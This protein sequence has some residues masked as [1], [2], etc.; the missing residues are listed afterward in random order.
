[1]N[2]TMDFP[3]L[4]LN[5]STQ[6][7]VLT[8]NANKEV[9]A[10]DLDDTDGVVVKTGAQSIGGVKTFTDHIVVGATNT[11]VTSV[12]DGVINLT[13]SQPSINFNTN[14]QLTQTSSSRVACQ[15]ADF[16]GGS[17]SVRCQLFSST[18]TGY[19]GVRNASLSFTNNNYMILQDTAGNTQTSCSAGHSNTITVAGTAYVRAYASEV[20]LYKNIRMHGTTSTPADI[21]SSHATFSGVSL[22]ADVLNLKK[23]TNPT[24]VNI[25]LPTGNSNTGGV[26]PPAQ[27]SVVGNRV[28]LR[29][30]VSL[31]SGHWTNGDTVLNTGE[32]STYDQYFVE[33]KTNA[34]LKLDT[35]GNLVIDSTSHTISTVHFHH[36]YYLN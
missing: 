32:S 3:Q 22:F 30:A 1:M 36:I 5:S 16:E 9:V 12:E 21:I 15:N 35:S 29:G 18:Y 6:S 17:S 10:R 23:V 19:A 20:H 34:V 8:L 31:N 24:W 26:A 2:A 25:T 11:Q 7:A 13:H 28:V 4:S 14:V 27:K 33:S